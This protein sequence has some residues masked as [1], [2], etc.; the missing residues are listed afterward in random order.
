MG[1]YKVAYDQTWH[2]YR[3][4]T[5]GDRG[6]IERAEKRALEIVRALRKSGKSR[7]VYRECVS[8]ETPR[9]QGHIEITFND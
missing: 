5:S 1:S 9:R 2:R 4:K 6:C 7:V 8:S 3:D